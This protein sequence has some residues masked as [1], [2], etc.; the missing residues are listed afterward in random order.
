MIRYNFSFNVEDEIRQE[1]L[2][3]MER[4]FIPS[5]LRGGLLRNASLFRLIHREPQG[6]TFILQLDSRDLADL[7]RFQEKEL[8]GL[9]QDLHAKFGDKVVFFPTEMERIKKW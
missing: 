9:L 4:E 5:L 6:E 2:D 7:R 1:W 3:F 8:S